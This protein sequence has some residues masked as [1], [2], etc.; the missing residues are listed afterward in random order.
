MGNLLKELYVLFKKEQYYF[1]LSLISMSNT[2]LIDILTMYQIK[3]LYYF[4]KVHLKLLTMGKMLA[5]NLSILTLA[6]SPI[7]PI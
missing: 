5:N 2:S 7:F 6:G 3:K 1:V 4:K